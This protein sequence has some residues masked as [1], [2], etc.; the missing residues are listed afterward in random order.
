ALD[1]SLE[2]ETLA[3]TQDRP[4]RPLDKDGEVDGDGVVLLPAPANAAT[5]PPTTLEYCDMPMDEAEDEIIALHGGISEKAIGILWAERAILALALRLMPW[6]PACHRG[7]AHQRDLAREALRVILCL[8]L[9]FIAIASE[10]DGIIIIARLRIFHVYVHDHILLIP[11]FP[12]LCTLHLSHTCSILSILFIP[13]INPNLISILITSSQICIHVLIC[14]I[15]IA[16]PNTI[17][18]HNRRGKLLV[19]PFPHLSGAFLNVFKAALALAFAACTSDPML[20]P[21]DIFSML[22]LSSFAL[23]RTLPHQAAQQKSC[24]HWRQSPHSPHCACSQH[25]SALSSTRY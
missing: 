23:P 19:R 24:S 25:Y 9:V 10:T 14:K 1:T 4:R 7:M 21:G 6:F 8:C 17:R 12:I 15:D 16:V 2:Q 22:L 13:L 3:P 11:S 20:F 18:L 5:D